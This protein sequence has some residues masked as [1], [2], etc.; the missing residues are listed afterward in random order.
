MD[1]YY[2][3]GDAPAGFSGSNT[4]VGINYEVSTCASDGPSKASARY[5]EKVLGKLQ[6]Q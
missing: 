2:G 6:E 5:R 3:Y 4:Y 1:S